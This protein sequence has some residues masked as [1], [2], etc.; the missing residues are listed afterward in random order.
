MV[1]YERKAAQPNIHCKSPHA[2]YQQ[3]PR[4]LHGWQER[5]SRCGCRGFRSTRPGRQDETHWAQGILLC[6]FYGFVDMYYIGL[7]TFRL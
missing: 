7:T 1:Q 4:S 5:L 3:K 2:N 6:G